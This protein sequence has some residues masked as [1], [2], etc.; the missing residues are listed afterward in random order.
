MEA[1][2][3][4]KEPKWP[5]NMRVANVNM[6]LNTDTM[7]DAPDKYHKTLDSHAMSFNHPRIEICSLPSI[8]ST[9]SED[10]SPLTTELDEFSSTIKGWFSIKAMA[11]YL[12]VISFNPRTKDQ[13]QQ[14]SFF[15]FYFVLN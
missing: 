10:K 3:S 5:V 7:I 6:K 1:P 8:S 4:G 2:A 11:I 13:L 15:R 12:A 9:V 14:N